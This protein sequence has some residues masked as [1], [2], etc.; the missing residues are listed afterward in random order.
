MNSEFKFNLVLE[1]LNLDCK[2]EEANVSR[3]QL[4][5]LGWE[6]LKPKCEK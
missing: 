3:A 6:T 1:M 5:A 4:D 2:I